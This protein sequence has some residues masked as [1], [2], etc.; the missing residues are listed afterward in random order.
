[1]E[2]MCM[3]MMMMTSMEKMMCEMNCMKMMMDQNVTWKWT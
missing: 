3:K 1:M 2:K